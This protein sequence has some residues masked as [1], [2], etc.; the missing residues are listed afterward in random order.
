MKRCGMIL[1]FVLIALTTNAQNRIELELGTV[2]VYLGQPQSEVIENL[3]HAGYRTGYVPEA[4]RGSQ[5]AFID[6]DKY[7]YHVFFKNGLLFR[8][9]RSWDNGEDQLRN[10]MSALQSILGSG[11][12][13]NCE[14]VHH[15]EVHPDTDMD[16]VFITCG[17]KTV[18]LGLGTIEGVKNFHGITEEIGQ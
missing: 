7:V 14:I 17:G 10:V 18:K 5:F 8:A 3:K 9:T 15:R 1:I 13:S 12:S 4:S 2:I 11:L 6:G 16:F